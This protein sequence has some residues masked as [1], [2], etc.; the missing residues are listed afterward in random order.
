MQRLIV[1][2]DW[3]TK[4]TEL[5]LAAALCGVALAQAMRF[6]SFMSDTA[7]LMAAK[8]AIGIEPIKYQN[9]ITPPRLVLGILALLALAIGLIAL[10]GY[11]SGLAAAMVTFGSL[12]AGGAFSI[13]AS[14]L[15]GR[16]TKD[17]YRA[18]VV[19]NLTNREADY[20]RDGDQLRADAAK[21]FLSL[22]SQ[23]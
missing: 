15:S 21:R 13:F 23:I 3:G 4:M 17:T 10:A 7:K 18:I 11:Q 19:H 2:R 12:L 1:Q 20:R 9:S 5:N 14:T 22:V 16:P 8:E 6:Q